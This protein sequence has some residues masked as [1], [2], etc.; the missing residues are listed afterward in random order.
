[1]SAAEVPTSI[2][3]QYPARTDTNGNTWYRQCAPRDLTSISGAGRP[4]PRR[5]IR[6]TQPMR[7]PAP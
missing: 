6:A 3:Q 7:R 4:T 5:L 2:A 1:M